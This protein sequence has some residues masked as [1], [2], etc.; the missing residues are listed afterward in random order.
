MRLTAFG[1]KFGTLQ[2]ENRQYHSFVEEEQSRP[3]RLKFGQ[4]ATVAWNS[5]FQRRNKSLAQHH[6]NVA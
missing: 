6:S 1:P 3:A 5:L 4:R 2:L